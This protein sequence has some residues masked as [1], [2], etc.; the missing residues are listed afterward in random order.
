[1]STTE[2]LINLIGT[3]FRERSSANPSDEAL[4]QV[5]NKAFHSRVAPLYLHIYKRKGWDPKLEEYFAF[6]RDREDMTLTVLK[7]LAANLNDLDVDG[8]VIFKSIKAYPAIPN[9]TDVLILGDKRA[10][11]TALQHLYAQGYVFHEWAPMQTTLYDSRGK[12]KIG[13]GKKGGIYYIDIYREISTDYIRYLSKE[14]VSPYIIVKKIK[15]VDVRLL[16]R[17]IELAIILFH[18]VFPE[19]TYELEHFYMPLF[20]FA[21]PIFDLNLFVS[22]VEKNWLTP[23]VV[24]N[25]SI[26]EELHKTHFSFVPEP[27]KKL[28]RHWS[29]NQKEVARF[30]ARKLET[31]HMF[32]PRIFSRCFLTKLRDF[33]CLSSLFVQ[34]FHMLNPIFFWGVIK[35]LRNRFSKQG[36]YHM[37]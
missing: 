7:D 17:E 4:L 25:L 2:N 9:D 31:P 21:D 15:G 23:A 1:M 24:A 28:L 22:F 36:V 16:Q 5:Y 33:S 6:V 12:G 27:L 32:S 10:F 35:S 8:Y 34:F 37:Q 3:P 29:S 11:E 20:Y 30:R 18:N 14:A 13:E 26:I 19:R